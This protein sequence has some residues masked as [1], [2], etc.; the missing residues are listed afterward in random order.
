MSYNFRT[1][2]RS[3]FKIVELFI[4]AVIYYFLHS[5]LLCTGQDPHYQQNH[6]YAFT[7][8]LYFI[9]RNSKNNAVVCRPFSLFQCLSHCRTHE[10]KM[11]F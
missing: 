7:L 4:V 10:L 5:S 11:K 8:S 3:T 1:P 9:D 2:D 6:L